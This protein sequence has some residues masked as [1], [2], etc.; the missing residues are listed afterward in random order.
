MPRPNILSPGPHYYCAVVLIRYRDRTLMW[1]HCRDEGVADVERAP[2][3]TLSLGDKSLSSAPTSGL[4]RAYG[5]QCF[6]P[7]MSLLLATM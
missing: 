4:V 7:H 5:L 2:N 6:L 1:P 3:A